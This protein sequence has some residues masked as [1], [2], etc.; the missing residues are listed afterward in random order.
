MAMSEFKL[1]NKEELMGEISNKPFVDRIA[2]FEGVDYPILCKILMDESEERITGYFYPVWHGT[3]CIASEY[4][5]KV[6]DYPV[7]LMSVIMMDVINVCLM[8]GAPEEIL[9]T[10]IEEK[11]RKF[12]SREEDLKKQYA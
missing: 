4:A 11:N 1:L 6:E 5:I 12:K 10:I 9:R 2:Q 3:D 7:S 8:L